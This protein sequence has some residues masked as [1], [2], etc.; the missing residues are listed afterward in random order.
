[1]KKTLRFTSAI[2]LIAAM[3]LSACN[4]AELI[5][6]NPFE[7]PG[8]EEPQSSGW[9]VAIS[10]TMGGTGTKALA[11]DPDTR[12]LIATFETTD[13]IFV[14]NKTKKTMDSSPL[15]PDRDGASVT[16]TGTLAGSY[17][18]GDELV[19]CYNSGSTG[20]FNYKD[21]EGTLPTVADYA[22]A[23]I[24][25]TAEDVS[26]KTITG[27]A[28]FVN[29][30]CIFGFN[31]TDGTYRVPVKALE[32][33][34]D[35][36]KLVTRYGL[37]QNYL[38]PNPYQYYGGI[39]I[40]ADDPLSGAVYVAL[41]NDNE[42]D[43]TYHFLVNDGAGHLYSGDKTAPAGKIVNG[44]FYSSTVALTPV[45]LPSV[46][47][48]ASGTPVGP[49]APWDPTLVNYGWAD[50]MFGY[51]NYGDLTISGNSNGSWFEWLTSDHSGGDRTVTLD[52]ATITNPLAE[53]V[54]LE[55][56][57][58][59]FTLVLSGAN[60]ITRTAASYGRGIP[61][62]SFK[63]SSICFQGDGTLAVTAATEEAYH[64]VKGIQGS[65]STPNPAAASGYT[66]TISDGT[67]NGD[68][69]TTWVY[70]VAPEPTIEMVDLGLPSGTLWAKY[71]LGVEDPTVDPY[72]NYY[73]WG[74]TTPRTGYHTYASYKL[75]DG[76]NKFT[77]LTKYIIDDGY[78]YAAGI[79]GKTKLEPS[80][81]AAT[82]ALGTAYC[83]PAAEDWIELWSGQYVTFQWS[84][85]NCVNPDFPDLYPNLSLKVY[86]ILVRSRSN[87]NSIFLPAAGL[88]G[89]RMSASELSRG[90]NGSSCNYWSSTLYAFPNSYPHS[91]EAYCLDENSSLFYYDATVNGNNPDLALS[92]N[93]MPSGSRCH[94]MPVRPVKHQ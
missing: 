7:Q 4:K 60:S 90:Q 20:I 43:D 22:K 26:D 67:D 61:A 84:Y 29:T 70:T 25:I 47:I 14:Y 31:F 85:I 42:G 75:G 21:Q 39:T 44:K 9:K 11:E 79:D 80:D 59:G 33:K 2:A 23:E 12:N 86:G 71:N 82:A 16:L 64:C 93:S 54:P 49:N 37:W 91:F 17:E 24:N 57:D 73:A 52:G 89:E 18:E 62:I 68:G 78:T 83:T 6:D 94:G 66:L 87:G 76:T 74:E 30:Q 55:N 48:T 1:M 36:N 5:V 32:V 63:G 56:Q 35:G 88:W 3:C 92:L 50:L 41:R 10:A 8:T 34:T 65:D 53:T 72:G 40:V 38:N 77:C 51:A 28:A 46:T 13:K 58:G 15:H 69:T 27:A 81:D 45:A 19:L